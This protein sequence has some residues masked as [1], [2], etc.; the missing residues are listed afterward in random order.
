M[1]DA[2]RGRQLFAEAA[3]TTE[4][5]LSEDPSARL[6][7]G[8]WFVLLDALRN[9]G[10][11]E[12]FLDAYWNMV[13]MHGQWAVGRVPPRFRGLLGKV[14][15]CLWLGGMSSSEVAG[16]VAAVEEHA[17]VSVDDGWA[18]WP[19]VGLMSAVAMGDEARW[20]RYAEICRERGEPT[21]VEP[22]QLVPHAAPTVAALRAGDA[23]RFRESF[24][25]MMGVVR[26]SVMRGSLRIANLPDAV[27]AV[28]MLLWFKAEEQGI[29]VEIDPAWRS[30]ASGKW[31]AQTDEQGRAV[32]RVG[33]KWR[34]DL[35]PVEL[36]RRLR[37]GPPDGW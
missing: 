1:D 26:R 4:R 24:N 5:T 31:F 10:D 12:R 19:Q 2:E 36:Y 28:P 37:A 33:V 29:E 17:G 6:N 7:G 22:G 8:L 32:G 3:G 20:D 11:D 25:E 35:L 30:V 15:V 16:W 18:P 14:P 21:K 23:E 27:N 13:R 9:L 34:K